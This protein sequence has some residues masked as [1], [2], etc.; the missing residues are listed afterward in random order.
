LKYTVVLFKDGTTGTAAVNDTLSADDTVMMIDTIAGMVDSATVVQVGT[1]FTVVG[2]A[3]TTFKVTDSNSNE[4]QTVTLTNATGGTFTLTF[5]GQPTGNIAY[6]AD[7][8]AVQSAMEG[9]SNVDVGD[10]AVT[11]VSGGPHTVEFKGQYLGID[12]GTMV[13]DGAL[14]TGTTPTADVAVLNPGATTWQLTFTPAIQTG[15]VPVDDAVITFSSQMIEIKIGDG[16]IT[17]TENTNY[18]YELDRGVL[19][20]VREGD[21]APIDVNVD[22]VYEYITTGTGEEITPMDALKGK[23]GAAGWVSSSSDPCEPYSIDIE[24]VYTPPCGGSEKEITL[25]PEFRPDTKEV[26]FGEASV[27]ITGRCNVVEPVVTRVAQ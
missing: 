10:V 25:F 27:S 18:D 12:V 6:D 26:D 7:G 15:S 9:L 22:F 16:N 17:Y 20:T 13:A 21:Q 8:A 11:G 4:R 1:R 5:D 2:D 24:V 14:L 19:D 3:A 23:G